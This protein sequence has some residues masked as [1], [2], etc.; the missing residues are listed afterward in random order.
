MIDRLKGCAEPSRDGGRVGPRSARC[1]DCAPAFSCCRIEPWKL[2]VR[3]KND[4]PAFPHGLV[5]TYQV[6]S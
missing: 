5:S 1:E 3:K 6:V 4:N 2:E